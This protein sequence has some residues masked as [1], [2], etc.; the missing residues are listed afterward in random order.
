MKISKII[1]FAA[2]LMVSIAAIAQPANDVCSGATTLPQNCTPVAGTRVAANDNWIG[3]VGCAGNN[4]E[5]WY[6]FVSTGT[7][8][9]WTITSGTMGGNVEFIL[10]TAANCAS[11]QTV[12]NTTCGASPL[13]VSVALTSG[14]NYYVTISSTGAAGTF[15]IS[16]CVTSPP[17]APGQDCS[18]ASILCNSTSFSQGTSAAGFGT[19][20]VST[21]NSCWGSGGERQSKWFKFSAGCTGALHFNI[22]PVVSGDD[23]DWALYDITSDPTGCTT[24]GSAV[25]CNW[26]GCKGSTGMS[27]CPLSEPGV[28][29]GGAGCFGNPSA[30]RNTTAGTYTPYTVTAGHCYAL[31]VDNFT[32]SNSGFSLTWGGACGGGITLGPNAAFSYSLS[33]CAITTTK[34]CAISPTTNN[35]YLWNWGDATTSTTMNGSHTY[36]TAGTYIVTLTVTD[37]LGCSVTTSQT[38]VCSILPVELLRFTGED[39]G[40]RQVVLDWETASERDNAFFTIERSKDGIS[41]QEI[42]RIPSKAQHGTSSMPLAYQYV[43]NN[44]YLNEYSY[45]RLRQTDYNGQNETKGIV[46]VRVVDNGKGQLTLKPNPATNSFDIGY[47]GDGYA[48]SLRIYDYTGRSVYEQDLGSQNGPLTHTIDISALPAGIYLVE[49]R[50]GENVFCQKLVRL[51]GE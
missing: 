46:S 43:D 23:Y 5:V 32:T 1:S 25:A 19:Q 44:P 11:A 28:N 41:F 7:L 40:N 50:E 47:I 20:E 15:T 17:P 2:A 13:N 10:T 22:N 21:G 34:T 42:A 9:Q 45:Y 16:L 26:S 29:T 3:T 24:K 51:Q 38:V 35:T 30:W 37:L 33:G 27:S 14:Q 36:A 18:N 8:G 6:N 39:N 4:S 49:L 31:L 48:Q 12:I